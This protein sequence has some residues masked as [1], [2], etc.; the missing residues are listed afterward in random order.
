MDECCVKQGAEARLFKTTFLDRPCMIKERFP[1]QYRHPEL[2]KKL[3]ARRIAQESR[4]II[5]CREAGIPCPTLF[6]F[7]LSRIYM[8]YIDNAQT[9]RDYINSGPDEKDLFTAMDT[10]GTYLACMHDKDIIHG[11]LTTSNIM[12]KNDDSADGKAGQIVM[13]D[14]GLSSASS[15]VEDKG[16]D[17]YVLERAFLSTH[18]N[19]EKLFDRI[20]QTYATKSEN[21][22]AVLAKLED[23]RARGRKR[24]MLG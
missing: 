4:S 20:I 12:R 6:Y 18:P 14:F 10:V 9:L 5:R 23:V 3:T 16:V 2:D 15:L 8:E 13:I 21:E 17:L 11:D 7:D 24:T 1:K 22:K 19:S